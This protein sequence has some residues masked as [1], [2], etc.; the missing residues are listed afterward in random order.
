VSPAQVADQLSRHRYAAVTLTHVDTSTG[1]AAPVAEFARAIHETET[2][3]ILDSVCALGGMPVEMDDWG[4]DVVLTGAQKAL[5]VPP[6]LALLLLSKRALTRRHEIDRVPAYYA[7]LANWEASMSDPKVYFST[8]AVNLFYA[9]QAALEIVR[10]EGLDT[11]FARHQHLGSAFRAGMEVFGFT[12]L[13]RS[14]VLAPTLSVVAYPSGVHHEAFR[15]GLAQHGV[16]AAGCLGGFKGRGIRFGHMG[17]IGRREIEEALLAVG[18]T[19]KDLGQ[20]AR[21]GAAVDSALGVFS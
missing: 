4:I 11:R 6:G 5:G 21:S 3:S 17:N 10:S 16:I 1:V 13:T 9:L 12:P 8:H 7:D 2:L 19:L 14:V 15:S 18:E 20:E